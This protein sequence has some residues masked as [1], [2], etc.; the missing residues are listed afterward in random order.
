MITTTV[1]AGSDTL[2]LG[3]TEDAYQGDAQFTIGIDGQ[4]VGGVLTATSPH[5]GTSSDTVDVLGD[6]APGSHTVAV[7]FLNDAYG[8]AATADR[9]LYVD[10]ATYDGAFVPGVAQELQVSGPVS[11]GVTDSTPTPSTSTTTT[12][13]A[14]SDTLV[15]KVSQDAY[16]GN[17]QFTIALDGQQVGGVLTAS[18]LHS[19][20]T[21]DTVNVLAN[22]AA[23][24]HMVSVNFLNDAY[25]GTPDTDRNLYVDSATYDGTAVSGVAQ[26]LY[27]SG[28]ASFNVTDAPA[29]VTWSSGS[30]EALLLNPILTP[31]DALIVK[32]NATVV[33]E[34]SQ[35][36]GVDVNLNG[37]GPNATP[38]SSVA[39]LTL[40]GAT[41]G[42]LSVIYDSNASPADFSSPHYGHLDVYGQS[43]I[44]GNTTLGGGRPVGPGFLDAYLHGSD[45]VL[46]L[47]GA[48]L[49]GASTLTIAGDQG[50]TV[51][52]DGNVGIQGGANTGSVTILTNL[53]GTGTISGG[54]DYATDAAFI[55]LG[56]DVGAGQTINLTDVHLELDQPMSFAGTLAGFNDGHGV[57]G[58]PGPAVERGVTPSLLM[59][60]NETVTGTSFIQA[61]GGFGD[62]MVS[63][64]G[65]AAGAAAGATLDFHV[66]GTFTPD[67]FAFTNSTTA[68]SATIFLTSSNIA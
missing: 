15:L 40:S 9:N 27:S 67:A 12:I 28:P 45:N 20:G 4:Q 33:A 11:F 48:S 61:S 7:N 55:R 68:Q 2:A 64:Q 1:G 43:T 22:L 35:L 32:G 6:W 21:S 29:T 8:G 41:V 19:S 58:Q 17:A 66:A 52:N 53:E 38:F 44:T 42:S 51:E 26:T 16:Q 25:G 59:L 60:A 47:H 36:A 62:L 24:Q 37:T 30:T 50:S 23:G 31:G 63:T 10:G 18:S 54:A 46:I 3:V 57:V 14:G 5:S 65:Q 49:G 39:N 34:G 13:G 56:G